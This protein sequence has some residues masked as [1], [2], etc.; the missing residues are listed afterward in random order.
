EEE[1]L[2]NYNAD[3]YYPVVCGDVLNSRY[4]VIQKMGFGATSTVWLSRDLEERRHVALKIYIN[5]PTVLVNTGVVREGEVYEYLKQGP[6]AHPGRE[7]VRPVLDSFKITGPAGEHQC[8]THPPLWGDF[9]AVCNKKHDQFS[10]SE[11]ASLLK[12]MLHAIDY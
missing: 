4:Q 1:M 3:R 10:N 6:T 8:I 5:D 7:A 2:D 11:I 12:R 9:R